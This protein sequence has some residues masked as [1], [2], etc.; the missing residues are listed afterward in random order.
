MRLH[1][2][3]KLPAN[4]EGKSKT[5]I[6][7]FVTGETSVVEVPEEIVAF[8]AEA[9]KAEHALAERER[10]HCFSMDAAEYE[11]TDYSDG[12]TPETALVLTVEKAASSAL[13]QKALSTLTDV[14]KRRFLM[15]LSGMKYEEI[16]HSESVIL[17]SVE[18]SIT[19]ARKKLK[20]FF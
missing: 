1:N 7:K 17:T 8:L 16:A 12:T 15:F 4:S 3:S 10:N 5:V 6:Y 14:Q 13:V 20:K 11:G 18:S 19:Q 9:D 2:K